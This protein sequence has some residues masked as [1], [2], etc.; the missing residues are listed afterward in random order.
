MFK[1]FDLLQLLSPTL[2]PAD[3]KLHMAVWNGKEHPLDVFLAGDFEEWQRWQTKR[4]FERRFVVSLI[5]IH[6][7]DNWLFSGLYEQI[8]VE[9]KSEE[10]CFYYDLGQVRD[11]AELSGRLVIRFSRNFRATYLLAE[12]WSEDLF[13]SELKPE[14]LTLSEFPGFKSVNLSKRELDCVIRQNIPSWKG[15]LS[16]VSGVYVISDT[17]S[18]KLYV[19]SAY[20]EG[21]IW[22]R[23]SQYSSSGHGNNVELRALLNNFGAKS[24]EAFRFSILEVADVHANKNEVITRETHWKE[25]LLSRTHGYNSN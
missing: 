15:A 16:S 22:S 17:M 13:V 8:G 9:F 3:C 25:V 7:T 10:N 2:S 18:G 21:G 11:C 12:R 5:N 1:L 24:A 20:G 6:G 19:G 23:W 4:N 14:R